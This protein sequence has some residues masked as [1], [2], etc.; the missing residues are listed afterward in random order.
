MI[1]SADDVSWKNLIQY[2][3]SQEERTGQ[4]LTVVQ[5]QEHHTQSLPLWQDYWLALEQE[6]SISCAGRMLGSVFG[7]LTAAAVFVT[8]NADA[9]DWITAVSVGYI[10][11]S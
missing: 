4:V 1:N 9:L 5:W 7:V 10:F 11:S 8:D 3:Q 6:R 2:L